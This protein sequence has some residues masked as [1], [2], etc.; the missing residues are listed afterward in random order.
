MSSTQGTSAR[1][2]RSVGLTGGI[3]PKELPSTPRG[4]RTR[5]KLIEA[6]RTVFERDGFLDARLLDITTEAQ[7]SAGSFYT[8]F[9]SKEEILAAVLAEVEEEMLHPAIEA[10]P[11]GDDPISVIRS[12]NR[13]YL[14]S[15]K[16]NAKFMRLLN[17][18]ASIDDGFRELRRLRGEAFTQRNAHSIAELQKAGIADPEVDAYL[19][20]SFLSGMVGRAA[21]SRFVQGEDWDIDAMVETLTTLWAN[22]LKIASS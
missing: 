15:Y 3:T 17:Q 16:R 6:A 11:M 13:A 20:A 9:E 8:Y 5:T 18:V 22:A 19:A 1:S 7:I 21:F 10:V 2:R 12:S 4:L 14:E